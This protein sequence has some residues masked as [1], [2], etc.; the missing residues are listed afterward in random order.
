[1]MNDDT[2]KTD[3]NSDCKHEHAPDYLEPVC[4]LCGSAFSEK[5]NGVCPAKVMEIF[6]EFMRKVVQEAES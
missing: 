3:V 5:Y 4:R 2:K 1:M 6:V